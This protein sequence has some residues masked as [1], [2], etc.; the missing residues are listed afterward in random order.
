MTFTF[1][2]I[3]YKD[4]KEILLTKHYAHRLPS[5]SYAYGLFREDALKGV[6]TFGKPASNNLC[7]GVA[8][9]EYSGNVIELNRL[10]IDDD[11]SRTFK[12]ITSEF[13]SYAL[14]QLKKENKI[15]VSYADSGMNHNGYIYQALNFIYTGATKERT[16]IF[17]G[18]GKHSRHYD[19]SDKQEY[20]IFRSS[21]HRYIYVCGDKR[22]KKKVLKALKYDARPYP[23]GEVKRYRVGEGLKRKYKRLSDNAI[24]TEEEVK[25]EINKRRN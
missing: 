20:R 23:K 14:R 13:V 4:T 11:I 7:I 25:K 21:K 8:G 15:V 3:E 5:I 19:K 9:K 24:L 17:T 6:V 16:D 10:Y 18:F 1:E 12:N 22:F 2:K